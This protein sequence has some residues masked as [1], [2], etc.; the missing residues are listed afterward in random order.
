[1]TKKQNESIELLH[2]A[3]PELSADDIQIISQAAKWNTYEAGIDLCRQGEPGSTLFV[4]KEGETDII[5]HADD[6][7]EILVDTIGPST[8]FG[9]MAF[10]G[11]STRM[12]TIRTKTPCH[13][14]EMDYADFMPIANANPELLRTLLRQIIGHLRRND[15]AVINELNKRTAALQQ[16]YAD[17]AEQEALRS[18]FIAT[19]AH[20]LR[21]PLTSI[22][23]FLGL[24]SQGAIK[25]NSLKVVMDSVIRNVEK[26][27]ALT[28]N[29]LILY[30]MHPGAPEYTYL[31]MAD[32]IVSA[33]NQTQQAVED[34]KG[35]AV[36]LDIAPDLPEIYADK[37]SLILG[38]RAL[39]ENAFKF[40]PKQ[41]P[42]QIK[43]FCHDSEMVIE[44]KDE[45]VGIP[46]EAHD[47]IFEPFFRLETE[48]STH[49]FPG[50]GIGLTIT[51]FVVE[52]HNGRIELQSEPGAGST[53]SIYLPLQ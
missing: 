52:R 15:R 32:L 16:A 50:L 4:L 36:T 37:R 25:G 21:T 40:N 33:L 24:I 28:N 27:V 22:R 10:F 19:L 8:Y 46:A 38:M 6:G 49:L 43:V 9:E 17:L 1:M 44:V 29:M 5:V 12:A 3:F 34:D 42:V 53:F 41:K 23:G 14:L 11:E 45:G 39:I 2:K 51:K 13:T 18:Q 47:Y 20:E 26:L 30:E 31:N 7:H 35:T 48:G